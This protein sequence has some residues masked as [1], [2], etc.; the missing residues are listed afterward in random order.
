LAE[1]FPEA[2]VTPVWLQG[3]G[4]V[5]PK[6]AAFPVPMNCTVLVGEPMRWEGDKT[7]FMDGLRDRLEALHA[8]APPQRW[9]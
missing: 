1:A 2:P 6:G 3:A 5:L 4:R 9:A 7:V 8:E